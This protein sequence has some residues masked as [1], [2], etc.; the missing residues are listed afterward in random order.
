MA[1]ALISIYVKEDDYPIYRENVKELNK[2]G[3]VA[4]LEKLK[5]IVEKNGVQE[6]G[7]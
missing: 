4:F 6:D 2:I 3:R 7:E 5:Q 1:I